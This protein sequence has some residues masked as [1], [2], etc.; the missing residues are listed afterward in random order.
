[1]KCDKI[2]GPP[3]DPHKVADLREVYKDLKSI[4]PESAMYVA[5]YIRGVLDREM[6]VDKERGVRG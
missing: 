2:Y 6:V 3:L 1:M 4:P 5:G